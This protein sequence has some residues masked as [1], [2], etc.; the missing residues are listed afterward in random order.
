LGLGFRDRP[1]AG[2]KPLAVS[3]LS[4]IPIV[5]PLLFGQDIFVYLSLAIFAAVSWFLAR[6]RGGLVLRAV[7]EAPEAAACPASLALPVAAPALASGP[8]RVAERR[9]GIAPRV[10]PPP[11]RSPVGR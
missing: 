1:I 4:D 11:R 8:S 10:P 5:G 9:P 3:G 2:L 7:G 6:S